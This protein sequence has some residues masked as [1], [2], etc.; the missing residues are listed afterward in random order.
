MAKRKRVR[1]SAT[2]SPVIPTGNC[3][4]CAWPHTLLAALLAATES[5]ACSYPAQLSD[6]TEE[7]VSVIFHYFLCINRV[8]VGTVEGLTMIVTWSK[9]CL[10]FRNVIRSAHWMQMVHHDDVFHAHRP[11]VADR[12]LKNLMMDMMKVVKEREDGRAAK[13]LPKTLTPMFEVEW[14]AALTRLQCKKWTWIAY[15]AGH[16]NSTP[17]T[18]MMNVWDQSRPTLA[19]DKPT[20]VV[21]AMCVIE[22]KCELAITITKTH[23][24]RKLHLTDADMQLIPTEVTPA[25]HARRLP[26]CS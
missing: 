16:E 4:S 10:A 7:I 6:M 19:D 15:G 5:T 25:I 20:W 13:G 1:H 26:R 23:A 9:T 17:L 3:L 11:P 8:L 22:Y 12:Q 2:A 14:N 24:M 18:L 21:P